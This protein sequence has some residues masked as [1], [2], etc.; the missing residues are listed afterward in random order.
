MMLQTNLQPCS[1]LLRLP[2]R[3]LFLFCSRL[4]IA[5]EEVKITA[6]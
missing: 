1:F 6:A 5:I 4:T 2:R 3:D